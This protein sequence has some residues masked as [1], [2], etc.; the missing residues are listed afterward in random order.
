MRPF[1]RPKSVARGTLCFTLARRPTLALADL[2]RAKPTLRIVHELAIDV[3][4]FEALKG[5]QGAG[6]A[7]PHRVDLGLLVLRL[8]S[9]VW[10]LGA[11]H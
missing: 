1:F 6:Q 8:D 5:Q 11:D 7:V 3:F 2:D 10:Q 9:K 4:H